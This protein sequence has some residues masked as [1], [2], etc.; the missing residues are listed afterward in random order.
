[1]LFWF[2]VCSLV[3]EQ[4]KY[5]F[6]V[7]F[8]LNYLLSLQVHLVLLLMSAGREFLVHV[9]E[10]F[11]INGLLVRCKYKPAPVSQSVACWNIVNRTCEDTGFIQRK[12]GF[13]Q[14]EHNPKGK[15]LKSL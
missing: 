5:I 4:F 13:S 11:R 10:T 3:T 6:D 9:G 7:V 1:M 12:L 15:N 2:V 14:L 8:E